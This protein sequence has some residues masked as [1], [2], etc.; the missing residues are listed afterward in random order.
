[1]Q[2]GEEYIIRFKSEGD[3]EKKIKHHDVIKGNIDFPENDQDI[4]IIKSDGLPTY[5][6]AHVVD[7]YLMRTTHVIRGDEWLSSLPVHLELF[8]AL[9]NK[10]T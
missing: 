10:T 8:K 6:F 1:M 4:V 9:R 7:D 3:I 2:N 5:H